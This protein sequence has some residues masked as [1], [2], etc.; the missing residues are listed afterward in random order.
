MSHHITSLLSFQFTL[1][2]ISL[3][4]R[5]GGKEGG[6]RGKNEGEKEGGRET[7]KKE[8]RKENYHLKKVTTQ[9]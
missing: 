6:R 8:G 3:D 9:A 4:E 2:Y 1:V 7:E 5:K